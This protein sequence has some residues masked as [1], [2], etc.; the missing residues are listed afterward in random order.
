MIQL[1]FLLFIFLG[2]TV[3]SGVFNNYDGHKVLTVKTTT[4]ENANALLDIEKT[5]GILVDFWR[6]PWKGNG[7]S[8]VRIAPE[9]FA[10]FERFLKKNKMGYDVMIED[11]GRVICEEQQQLQNRTV[12]KKTN[13]SALF[14]LNEFHTVEEIHDYLRALASKFQSSVQL[15]SIGKSTKQRDQLGVKIGNSGREKR[16]IVLNGCIHAREWLSCASMLFIISELTANAHAYQDI[17]NKLDFYIIPVLNPDGYT[18]S[19]T[20]DRMWRKTLSGPI[21]GCFGA[22]LNRN[23]DFKFMMAGS[24]SNP[25]SESF[26]G[27]HA[28][29]EPETKNLAN[30]LASRRNSV[31]AYF[32]IHCFG[33]LFMFPYGYA[34]I[35]PPDADDLRRVAENAVQAMN[36]QNGE[37]FRAGSIAEII[38]KVSGG[39]IDYAKAVLGINYTYAIELRPSNFKLPNGF[40]VPNAYII[41]G[42]QELWAGIRVVVQ[43]VISG[44]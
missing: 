1:I 37:K 30:F 25:C 11:V 27:T 7:T 16:S 36:A 22:D 35:Y 32:D 14:T 19:W 21:K 31:A 38:Y 34:K 24:S 4:G 26:A 13:D 8:D 6:E 3:Q 39:S 41:P 44:R 33:E 42:A 20:D 18:Y 5:E 28:F 29:S 9:Q 40:I 23:F 43:D 17:L 10:E 12:F 2:R 15:F